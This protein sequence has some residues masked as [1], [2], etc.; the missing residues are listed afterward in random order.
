MKIC[1][2]NTCHVWCFASLLNLSPHYIPLS[3]FA[4]N[5]V[6]LFGQRGGNVYQ[7]VYI[8]LVIFRGSVPHNVSVWLVNFLTCLNLLSEGWIKTNI[9]PAYFIEG[10]K[11]YIDSVKITHIY[12]INTSR[13]RQNG[14]HFADIFKRIFFNENVS[15]AIKISLQFVPEGPINNIPALVQMMALHQPGDKPL[16]EPMMVRSLAPIWKH[17]QHCGYWWLGAKAPDYQYPQCWPNI[18]CVGPVSDKNVA[19]YNE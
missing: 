2:H 3:S 13:L 10:N 16:S 17:T 1:Y 4:Y 7:V 15:I 5:L 9:L 8:A 18:Y 19:F 6:M 11:W 12:S 14:P